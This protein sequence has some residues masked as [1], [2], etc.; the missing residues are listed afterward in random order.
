[1][2]ARGAMTPGMGRRGSSVLV[3]PDATHLREDLREG[4]C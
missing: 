1:M 3:G 4:M 2:S